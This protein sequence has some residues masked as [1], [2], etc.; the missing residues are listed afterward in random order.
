MDF[1]VLFMIRSTGQ[2][3]STIANLKLDISTEMIYRKG[4]SPPWTPLPRVVA[5]VLGSADYL[6][7]STSMSLWERY[8]PS[9]RKLPDFEWVCITNRRTFPK[10]THRT[11]YW[12]VVDF[13]K[14]VDHVG[15]YAKNQLKTTKTL[16]FSGRPTQTV[17]DFWFQNTL[18]NSRKWDFWPKIRF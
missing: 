5:P 18:I 15:K 8:H 16:K 13:W 9:I 11:S 7:M 2:E 1:S 10:S 17:C 14:V 12:K 6:W 3:R 4:A